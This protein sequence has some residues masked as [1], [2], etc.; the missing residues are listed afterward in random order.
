LAGAAGFAA[1]AAS[2][3]PY[4]IEFRAAPEPGANAF[5]LPSGVIV[6]TDDLLKLAED[7]R[8]I[9]GLVAHECGHVQGRH[10]LRSVLQNSAVFVVI[11]L[12]TGDVSSTTGFAGA[13]PAFL[14]QN[15]FS[16]EFECEADRHA[17]T[18]LRATGNDPAFL[19]HMLERLS[20]AHAES[21]SKALG[22]LQTHPSTPE[23]IES[24]PGKRWRHAR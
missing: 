14:L 8:E 23:R 9:L 5:A 6:I 4:R 10:A 19:A 1:Q 17:V 2:A 11:A 12:I 3:T 16:R 24:I 21:G 13:L 15:K 7:D 20:K 22:Y 18:M